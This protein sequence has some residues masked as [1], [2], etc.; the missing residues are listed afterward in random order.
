MI[1]QFSG[2]NQEESD[3][4]MEAIP[5]VTVLIAGADGEI[6]KEEKEWAAKLTKIRSY[7]HPENWNDF[8]KSVGENYSEKL[9][10]LISSLPSETE[11][12]NA[13]ISTRLAAL[14]DLLPK[15]DKH[16][17]YSFYRGLTSFAE[18]VAKA[19]G[20]F[21]RIG[22]ISREEKKWIG[23]PMITPVPEPEEEV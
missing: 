2:L 19:S 20:G 23:L 12:R 18:H 16:A 4:M 3:L 8:Y 1:T 6:D 15:I 9:D 21:L 17:A 22:A 11:A 13:V 5:L 14:N 10:A 7:N